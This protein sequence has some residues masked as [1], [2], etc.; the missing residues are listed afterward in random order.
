MPYF[1]CIICSVYTEKIININN[2]RIEQ[3]SKSDKLRKVL[4]ICGFIFI[5]LTF[6]IVLKPEPFLR[7]GYAGIFLFNLIGPGTFLIP[8]LVRQYNLYAISVLTAAGMAVNDSV[9]WFVGRSSRNW[10]P[11]TKY[12]QLLEHTV[13]KYGVWALFFWALIPFPYDII[14]FIAGFLKISYSR[15]ITPTFIGRLIRF[16]LMGYGLIKLIY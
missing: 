12:L 9:S 16:I 8:I 10:T 6:L 3:L 4:T 5:I 2:I 1:S 7:M 11:N 13:D 15:F 14:G